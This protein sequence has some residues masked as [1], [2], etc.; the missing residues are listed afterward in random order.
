MKTYLGNISRFP[1]SFLL[2]LEEGT[3][4]L[5]WKKWVYWWNPSTKSSKATRPLILRATWFIIAWGGW[6]LL[7]I[8]R[9]NIEVKKTDSCKT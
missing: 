6:V 3:L 5:V 2:L 4:I 1:A 9:A 8:K 7:R